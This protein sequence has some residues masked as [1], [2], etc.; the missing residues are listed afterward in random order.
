MKAVLKKFL[1]TDLARRAFGFV[2]R[3]YVR[4]AHATTL[5]ETHN[6][7]SLRSVVQLNKG[8]I[9]AFWHNRLSLAPFLWVSRK[10]FFMLISDHRDGKMIAEIIKP[11]GIQCLHGSTHHNSVYAL[12]SLVSHLKKGSTVGITPDGPRG[13][14]YHVSQG[15]TF[16]AQQIQCPIICCGYAQKREFSLRTWDAFVVPLPFNRG[17]KVWGKPIYPETD[18]HTRE[19]L[20]AQIAASLEEVQTLAKAQLRK[21]C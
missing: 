8:F 1:K 20:A 15:I 2:L 12:K 5:W 3:Q 16:L 17:V 21:S 4:L 11:L 9:V 13:P 10:P 18:T 6:L 7:E 14:R 19:S